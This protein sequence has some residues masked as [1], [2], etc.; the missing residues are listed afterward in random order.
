MSE[1]A[2]SG[3][4][5]R[6][7]PAPVRGRRRRAAVLFGG[8][9]FLALAAAALMLAGLANHR[10]ALVPVLKASKEI[11][12]GTAISSDQLGVTYVHFQDPSTGL[13]V[14]HPDDRAR[15]VGQTAA[16][17]IPAGSLIPA[18]LANP[19]ATSGFW[20]ASLPVK[21]RPAGL[22][23]GD[24]VALIVETTKSGQPVD[25]VVMQD[26]QVLSVGPD[27]VDLWL[28]A[29][30]VAQMEWYGSHTTLVLARMPAGAVQQNLPPGGSG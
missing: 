14:A 26:V 25:V 3:G 11:R 27:A 4:Q 30:V 10:E 17:G 29:S 21:R 22:H 24:H 7:M 12:A 18:G 8:L 13:T 1:Q 20:D 9:L 19:Q 23:S 15:L 5:F 6:V 16:I 2:K 28:P